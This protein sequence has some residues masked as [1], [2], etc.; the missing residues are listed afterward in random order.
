MPEKMP[1]AGRGVGS[2]GEAEVGTAPGPERYLR[3]IRL[4][5][6]FLPVGTQPRASEGH[7]QYI[8]PGC[9]FSGAPWKLVRGSQDGSV[10]PRQPRT[11]FLGGK[12]GSGDGANDDGFLG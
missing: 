2:I 3:P 7:S 12:G 8:R 6:V 9:Y 10:T 1:G 11:S 4:F 5:Q